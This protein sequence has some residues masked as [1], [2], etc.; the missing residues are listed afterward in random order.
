MKILVI[1]PSFLPKIGGLE[2][3]VHNLSLNWT[4]M[5]HQVCVANMIS[6]CAAHPEADYEVRKIRVLRGGDRFGWHHF[7]WNRWMSKE[8]DRVIQ[9]FN[10][11]MISAHF[12]YPCGIWLA[13]V[14]PD[15]PWTITC[16]AADVQTLKDY[17]YGYR[18]RFNI[19]E[20][21]AGALGKAT[22]VI[23][24]SENIRRIVES[25]G[26]PSGAITRIPVGAD[27][28]LRDFGRD[29]NIRA[30]MNIPAGCP[31]LLSVGRNY[32]A[33]GFEIGLAAFAKIADRFPETYYLFIGKDTGI[34]AEQA[35]RLGVS[36]RIRTCEM[37]AGPHLWSAYRG[38][39]L[40]L[41]PSRIE[42]FPCVG[43]EAIMAG[44]PLV[45]TNCPGNKEV[46]E[47]GVNGFSCAVDDIDGMAR[48]LALLL[49]DR[50]LRQRLARGSRE[51]SHLYDWTD[52]SRSYLEA[53]FGA[54][55]RHCH[56]DCQD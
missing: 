46:L 47:H 49:A 33:K 44:L 7:P 18:L 3:A 39:I 8:I 19:D 13:G 25:L 53:C 37:L 35:E 50:E 45:M 1:T 11:D 42:G 48:Q 56:H 28:R 2:M 20:E 22:K 9:D 6:D 40:Y 5:G 15:I 31:Y 12:A 23:V 41:S 36:E 16:H 24:I 52:I 17:G 27:S 51:R 43:V 55:G 26:V 29:M 10:P 32:F 14:S 30:A 21:I 34:L 38:A 54:N 4:K